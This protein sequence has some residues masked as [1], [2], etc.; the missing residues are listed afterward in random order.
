MNTISIIRAFIGNPIFKDAT[1]ET[2]AKYDALNERLRDIP[3]VQYAYLYA[4]KVVV[5]FAEGK[6]TFKYPKDGVTSDWLYMKIA[7]LSRKVGEDKA[8]KNLPLSVQ[9]FC[10]Q[11]KE[12]QKDGGVVTLENE[13]YIVRYGN[14]ESRMTITRYTSNIVTEFMDKLCDETLELQRLKRLAEK[15]G[16]L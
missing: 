2:R 7:L 1:P 12:L 5:H 9:R 13:E 8:W 10:K 4:D 15:H 3:N 16:L 14:F 6:R 11:A